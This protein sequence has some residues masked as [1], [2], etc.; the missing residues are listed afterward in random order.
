M[1]NELIDDKLN[2]IFYHTQDQ[3][4]EKLNGLNSL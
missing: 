1:V 4:G 2:L 3:R